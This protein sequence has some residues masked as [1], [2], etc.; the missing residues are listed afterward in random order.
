MLGDYTKNTQGLR[1][2]DNDNEISSYLDTSKYITTSNI[3]MTIVWY[4]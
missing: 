4:N 1:C 2:Y 3:I